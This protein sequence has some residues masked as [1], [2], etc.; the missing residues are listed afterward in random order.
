[1]I[2]FHS[3]VLPGIDDGSQSVEES[4]A[5]LRMEAEQGVTHVVATPHFY[6]RYDDPEKFLEKRARAEQLLRNEMEKYD[7]MPTLRVGA[8]VYYFRGMSDSDILPHLMIQGSNCIMVEMPKAPWPEAAYQELRDIHQKR[9]ILPVIAHVDRYIRPFKTHAIPG[10]LE[11]LPVLVQANGEFF[12]E[13]ATAAMA[14]RMLKKGQIHLL[15]SDCHNLSSRKPNLG[16]AVDMIEQRLGA[17]AINRIL[18]YSMDVLG[19]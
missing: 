10:K 6:A 16:G 7:A 17:E 12:T 14:V 3:H 4:I 5:L 2:D 19:M 11:K 1:M 9:G 8:E 18:R 15:G 13:K